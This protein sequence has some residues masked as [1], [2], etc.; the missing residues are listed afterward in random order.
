MVEDK[1][2]PKLV[3][4]VTYLSSFHFC[5]IPNQITPKL[6][7]LQM[8]DLFEKGWKEGPEKIVDHFYKVS[9]KMILK[10]YSRIYNYIR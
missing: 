1:I 2:S 8:S 4:L 9:C 3:R 5:N 6:Q 10:I 7:N